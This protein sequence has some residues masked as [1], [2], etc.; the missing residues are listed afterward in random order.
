MIA[1]PQGINPLKHKGQYPD[2]WLQLW[3]KT[4]DSL[5]SQAFLQY[6]QGG[7]VFQA[8]AQKALLLSF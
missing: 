1:I 5:H 4:Q 3:Q 2:V 6:N 7:W 8:D